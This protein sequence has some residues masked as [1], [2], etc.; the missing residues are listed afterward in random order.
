M[1]WI[2]FSK[3]INPI[4]L[5][6]VAFAIRQHAV[7]LEPAYL[8]LLQY[9]PYLSLGL[10]SALCCYYNRSRLF[11]ATIS[12]L[13]IY[14][15]IQTHLQST[16]GYQ[17][18]MLIYSL[19]SVLHP[20][21]LLFLAFMPERGLFNRYGLIMSAALALTLLSGVF[22]IN[23]HSTAL[24]LIVTNWLPIKPFSGLV[25]SLPA[26]ACYMLVII[27][28][29]YRLMKH[30]DEFALMIISI[31]LFSFATLAKLNLA[32]ISAVMFI[33]V[34]ISLIISMMGASY[35]MA[36]RDELTGLLGR[37]ALND[38]LQGLA[39]EYAI[40]MMDVDHFKKFND[41]YGHDIGDE[42]LKMV[43]RKIGDVRGGGTAY[44]YGG[45][46]F[47][48]VFAGKDIDYCQPFLEDVRLDVQDYRMT[49]RDDVHRP[50]SRQ[51]AK[52]RRGRR[53]K[54]RNEKTVSVT[55]SIG[56]AEPDEKRNKPEIVLKAADNALYK[57][58]KKGRNCLV[59]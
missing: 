28:G 6:T 41:T 59:H 56:M 4:L 17:N 47:C 53:T 16:L 43:A 44:R 49:L 9:T 32:N 48:I 1:P 58:K 12:I 46:E 37:R 30:N 19:I 7:T 25:L 42:V 34:S 20:L 38:R 5:L 33:A 52:Q 40:A 39:R 35:D 15:L 2:S 45:E 10:V 50:K 36:Y 26:S 27:V 55:I 29:I 31:S 11:I 21:S 22:L 54:T 18:T 51:T 24:A 13:L 3:L 23:Y 57:A 14:Y 8:Q